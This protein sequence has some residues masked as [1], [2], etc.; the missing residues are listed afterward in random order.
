M[1]HLTT[2][3][4]Y[5]SLSTGE[6]VFYR[7][8]GLPT[9]PTVL[10][11]HGFPSSSY[12]YRNLISLLAPHYHV[13]A[14]DYPAFGFTTVP[15][16]YNYTFDNI[17]TTISTF[18]A[19]LPNSPEKY[20]IY[21]FDYGA[22]VGFRLALKH[23][24]KISAIISQNGNAYEEGLGAFWDSIKTFWKSDNSESARDPLRSMLTLKATKSQYRTGTPTPSSIAPESYSLDQYLLDRPG[25][26]E[27]QLDLLYDYRTNPPLYPRWQQWMKES[28]VPTLLVWGK[29]DFIFVKDGAELWKRDVPG[30][31]VHLLDAGHFAVES[32]AEGIAG[33]MV[34]FFGRAGI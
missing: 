15:D 11:F 19:E 2:L 12:Q 14:P 17:A 4:K 20:S 22:P 32:H 24:S 10:L 5:L 25:I 26:Q 16:G 27:I 21:I 30:A 6:S 23:P 33:L 29:N 13:L 3:T 18:L 28:T 9:L 1:T 8:A 7:E 31:E 34:G